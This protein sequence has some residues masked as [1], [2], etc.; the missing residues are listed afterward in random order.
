[1]LKPN[2]TK[3]E[4]RGDLHVDIL[5]PEDPRSQEYRTWLY[6]TKKNKKI[7]DY[8]IPKH[9]VDAWIMI[10]ERR[11]EVPIRKCFMPTRDLF[12]AIAEHIIRPYLCEGNKRTYPWPRPNWSF[13]VE[14]ARRGINPRSG[15]RSST[16]DLF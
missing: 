3:R 1:M 11:R 16:T 2:W 15:H 5:P 12:T 8:Q 14:H 10:L 6:E 7:K 9:I 13:W 4:L